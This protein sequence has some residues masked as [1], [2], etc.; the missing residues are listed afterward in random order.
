M[1]KN[2]WGC[3]TLAYVAPEVGICLENTADLVQRD[4]SVGISFLLMSS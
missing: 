2:A 3:G 1:G 4:I